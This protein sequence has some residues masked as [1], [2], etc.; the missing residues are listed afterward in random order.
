MQTQ[1]NTKL[2]AVLKRDKQL[3]YPLR[4]L[5]LEKNSITDIEI[6]LLDYTTLLTISSMHMLTLN[7]EDKITVE[8]LS[9]VELEALL[10][11]KLYMKMVMLLLKITL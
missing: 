2:Q 9:M 3:I 11:M 10:Q 4:M 8:M 6:K 7:L 1:I 5:Q